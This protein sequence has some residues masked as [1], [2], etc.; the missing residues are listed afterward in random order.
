[1]TVEKIITDVDVENLYTHVLAL[2]GVKHPLATP[3]ALEKAENYILK[4]FE[5]YG[6]NTNIQEFKLKGIDQTFR[7]IEGFIGNGTDP[8]LLIVSHHD[9]VEVAP[10]ADDN[11]SA[12]AVMLESARVL[13]DAEWSG[14]TRFISFTLEEGHPGRQQ[15]VKALEHKYG[16]KDEHNRY[17]TWHLSKL[18]K[19][20]SRKTR[21]LFSSG[22]PLPTAIHKAT[23]LIEKDLSKTELEYLHAL[24]KL[25]KPLTTTNWPGK[26]ALIGSSYWVD[27]A[28]QTKKQVK[29]V[30]CHD[31][32]GYTAKEEQSQR[33][34]KII[35]PSLFTIHGTQ[36][37]LSVGDFLLI[38]GDQ[39]SAELA[40]TFCT[41]AQRKSIDLPYA[42]FQVA[43]SFEQLA[44]TMTD[45]LRSDHAPFWRAGI[46]ALFFTD[47][48]E[49]RTPHYHKP[50]DTIDT[51]DFEFLTKICQATIATTIDGAS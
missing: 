49:F 28:I 50:S 41:N 22:T 18:M 4:E 36:K 5:H 39:N 24:E 8:E 11:A 27:E 21:E 37:D 45:V 46:P 10:G 13:Q 38:I 2:E 17:T 32:I 42:S 30:L 3:K 47:S 48:A 26:L 25:S 14:N 43:F 1:M 51:L 40:T 33:F 31:T 15:Q 9:T 6:L 35:S 16:I 34:H 29:G 12:I 23:V 44:Q 20:H 19:E 7:N